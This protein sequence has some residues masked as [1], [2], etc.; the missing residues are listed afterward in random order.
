MQIITTSFCFNVIYFFISLLS[1][2]FEQFNNSKF[3]ELIAIDTLSVLIA[4]IV[5]STISFMLIL[6]WSRD[7]YKIEN[8]EITHTR[9][10]IIKKIQKFNIS[11]AESISYSQT[12]LGKI[13]EYGDIKIH[14]PAGQKEIILRGISHPEELLEMLKIQN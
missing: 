4:I 14:Y 5:Q 11:K 8:E 12:I 1:D 10:I 3:A 7:S 9:G 2:Y 13:F 6:R